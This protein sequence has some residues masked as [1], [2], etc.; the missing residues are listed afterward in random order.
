ML[1]VHKAWVVFVNPWV[2]VLRVC[3]ARV[4][5]CNV[6]GHCTPHSRSSI[7]ILEALAYRTQYLWSFSHSQKYVS[8]G[9]I[10]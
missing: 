6:V 4:N 8:G 9:A 10:V 2:F 5:V 3:G 7:R 1:H